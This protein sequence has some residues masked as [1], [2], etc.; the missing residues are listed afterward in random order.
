MPRRAWTPNPAADPVVTSNTP[1]QQ[2][3]AEIAAHAAAQ[4]DK[5]QPAG[6]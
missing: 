4:N 3:L 1:D 2:L 5:H 6:S